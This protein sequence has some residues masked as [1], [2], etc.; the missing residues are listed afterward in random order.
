MPRFVA[1]WVCNENESLSQRV[2]VI[3]RPSYE[4]MIV[5]RSHTMN[6]RE[7]KALFVDEGEIRFSKEYAKSDFGRD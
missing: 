7:R 1:L 4:N 6:D 3:L 5:W 2:P